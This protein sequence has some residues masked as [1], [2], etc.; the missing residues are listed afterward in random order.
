MTPPLFP[1][2]ESPLHHAL[3]DNDGSFYPSIIQSVQNL[4]DIFVALRTF[5][6]VTELALYAP[7][8]RATGP[9]FGSSSSA[10]SSCL[11]CGLSLSG[12]PPV[13]GGTFRTLFC[14]VSST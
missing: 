3:L 6:V 5:S 12:P 10:S 4:E 11:L 9:P 13:A 7:P 1:S 14:Y 2:T 8:T